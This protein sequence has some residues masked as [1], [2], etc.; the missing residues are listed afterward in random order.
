M[1]MV[2]KTR[3]TIDDEGWLH[4]G[5]I[6]VFDDDLDPEDES[7]T[8]KGFLRITG[9]LKELI[10]TAGGEN[11]PPVLIEQE[12]MALLPALSGCMVVG[13][14]QKFLTILLALHTEI[15]EN[16]VPSN[17]L[18]GSSLDIA[19]QI[20]SSARTIEE[21]ITDPKWQDYFNKG[22]K[23]ANSKT[24]S[25]AQIVQKWAIV[26]TPFSERGG[27][28]TPTLKLK[29]NVVLEKYQHLINEM[30]AEETK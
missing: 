25:R 29:R 12:F 24:T 5:D 20:E 11:I 15:D 30:Y 6:G 27:E 2:D 18:T 21:V 3:E 16:G 8:A 13:D 10:I 22:M 9:R 17:I 7:E 23:L 1:K 19:N 14:R 26:P 28:L 4:S